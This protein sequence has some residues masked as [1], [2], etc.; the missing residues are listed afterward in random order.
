MVECWVV[1]KHE[2]LV[3]GQGEAVANVRHDLGLFHGVNAEFTLQILVQFNEVSRVAGVFDHDLNDGL[4]HRSVVHRRS[5][6][7]GNRCR[8]RGR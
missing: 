3:N 5:S 7:G 1:G 6:R 4:R 2:V 8:D